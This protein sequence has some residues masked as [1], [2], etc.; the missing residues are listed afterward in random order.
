M[1][2]TDETIQNIKLAYLQEHGYDI[3][4]SDDV[5]SAVHDVLPLGVV[6]K[7]N[8]MRIH[9]SDTVP[10]NVFSIEGWQTLSL[11]AFK[12]VCNAFGL[13]PVQQQDIQT[14]VIL[15]DHIL[16]LIPGALN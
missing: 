11:E 16:Q 13:V 3:E 9:V 12:I 6:F 8:T 1:P 2:T 4:K 5:I 10:V 15:P 14:T 7:N